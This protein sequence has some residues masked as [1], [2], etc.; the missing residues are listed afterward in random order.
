MEAA[1]RRGSPIATELIDNGVPR[2][3]TQLSQALLFDNQRGW[4]PGVCDGAIAESASRHGGELL[5]LGFTVSQVVH[6]YGDICQAVTEIAIA[7]EAPLSV[8]E[9]QI[10]NRSLDVAIAG[11][12]T[13]H[14]RLRA[15]ASLPRTLRN[16]PCP[17]CQSPRIDVVALR[18]FSVADEHHFRCHACDHRW[19][20]STPPVH[21]DRG[22]RGEGR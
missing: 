1:K 18:S 6:A 15:L 3:L 21:S 2:F 5:A 10:L 8:K 13:E 11:A 20:T 22:K 19:T 12:L 7:Q 14:A 4:T 9:F 17:K 16:L